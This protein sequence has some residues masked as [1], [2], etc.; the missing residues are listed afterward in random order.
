MVLTNE[1]IN[2]IVSDFKCLG[3][4]SRLKIIL[5]LM[6]GKKSVGEICAHTGFSQSSTSHSLRILKDAKI[7][8]VEKCGTTCFYYVLDEH[9][10]TIIKTS[11]E[12]RDC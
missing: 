11:I 6:D 12:H 2:E 9:V 5:F 8:G 3:D 4:F 1:K 7:L 10:R